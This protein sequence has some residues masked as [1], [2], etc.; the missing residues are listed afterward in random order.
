MG[1]I[2]PL[3]DRE[4]IA[5]YIDSVFW[6]NDGLVGPPVARLAIALCCRW[7]QTLG[8]LTLELRIH[9]LLQDLPKQT[10]LLESRQFV[11]L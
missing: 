1:K 2:W 9:H 10:Q 8:V 5:F 11:R 4:L 6:L 3:D 7:P